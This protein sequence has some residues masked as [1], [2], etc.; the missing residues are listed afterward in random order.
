MIGLVTR[1]WRWNK[2]HAEEAGIIAFLVVAAVAATVGAMLYFAAPKAVD[3]VAPGGPTI[4][5]GLID[6]AASARGYNLPR[7]SSVGAEGS[8]TYP[9][10]TSFLADHGITYKYVDSP[11]WSQRYLG[12]TVDAIVVHVASGTCP[13]ADSWFKNPASQVAAH[14]IVCRDGSIHQYVE[15]GDAAW[16]AGIVNK[17]DLSNPIIGSWV[18]DGINP[19]RRTV[20][21][22][23]ELSVGDHIDDYPAMKQSLELLVG[24][25]SQ[26]LS[27]PLDRT[28][29]IGHYQIDSVNRA[30]DP[31][32]CIDLDALIAGAAGPAPAT[33]PWGA[34][35]PAYGD[36]YLLRPA[37]VFPDGGVFDPA[38]GQGYAHPS[39]SQ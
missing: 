12:D 20:G 7:G 17:P 15:V 39:C 35:D 1:F 29:V 8:T 27:I 9:R 16:Q 38:A 14:F 36:S 33:S 18:N 11:N 23:T 5:A 3:V 30:A 25:L 2:R 28:H 24:W 22:E 6:E 13:G 34:C 21:I 19:N 26:T 32:C 31:V 4:S 37:W 10:P